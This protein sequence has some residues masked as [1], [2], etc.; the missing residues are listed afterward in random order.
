MGVAYIGMYKISYLLLLFL[1]AW[2][3]KTKVK[4]ESVISITMGLLLV[5]T[6]KVL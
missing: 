4:V 1:K 2:T 6:S 3:N 5:A